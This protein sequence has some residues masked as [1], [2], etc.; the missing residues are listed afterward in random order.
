VSEQAAAIQETSASADEV[1]AMISRN[2]ANAERSKT[3]SMASAE[4]AG[5]SKSALAEMMKSIQEIHASNKEI[6][7]EIEESN[8]KIAEIVKVI[9]DIGAKT[10]IINDIV[11][12]TKLLSFN[13]SVEA[14]RA[15]E[16]GKGFAVVAEE[17]GN[18][19]RMSGNAAR[20]ISEIL[21]VSISRVQSIVAETEKKVGGLMSASGARIERGTQTA[22][23]CEKVLDEVVASVGEVNSCVGEIAT[24]SREQAQGVSEIN[25]AM[26]QL[27]TLMQSNLSGVQSAAALTQKL[28]AQGMLLAQC[29]DEVGSHPPSAPPAGPKGAKVIPMPKAAAVKGTPGEKVLKLASGASVPSREDR[30]FEEV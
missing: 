14:A 24:A 22:R 11:F 18:L 19:A 5:R 21:E 6:N 27:D 9:R 25:R 7:R 10:K 30:R 3:M 8:H 29:M 1:N 15:G 13:A 17:V 4:A 20:E 28:K 2:A 26:S 12:Q 16:H 23:N